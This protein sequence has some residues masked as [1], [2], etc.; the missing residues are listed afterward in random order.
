VGKRSGPCRIC[1]KSGTL[2]FEH[3]PPRAAFNK[4]PIVSIS[5]L[6]ALNPGA[7]GVRKV[8]EQRGAGH[9]SLCSDCNSTTGSWYADALR[10]FCEQGMER[11]QLSV[12]RASLVY[13][14]K[15]HP[16]RVLK[17]VV[18]MTFSANDPNRRDPRL[19]AFVLDRGR[20]RLPSGYRA[21]LYFSVGPLYRFAGWSP[22]LNTGGEISEI[23]YPPFGYVLT[24]LTDRP[25]HPRFQEITDFGDSTYD[26]LEVRWLGLPSMRLASPIPGDYRTPEVAGRQ[27]LKVMAAPPGYPPSFRMVLVEDE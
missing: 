1:G 6:Q 20:R 21:Y 25:P 15:I 24:N 18:A 27:R 2:T 4:R 23:A 11:A 9:H 7:T 5:G 14:Y 26:S 3:V 16:L 19:V 10:A 12:G 13:P 17:Q 8:H 22:N